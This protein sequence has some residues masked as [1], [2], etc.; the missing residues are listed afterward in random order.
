[1]SIQLPLTIQQLTSEKPYTLDSTGL[2][3]S[4]IRIYDDMVLKIEEYID[5]AENTAKMLRWLDGKLPAPRL[6][7][8][9]IS[10]GKSYM[11]MSRINGRMSCDFLDEQEMVVSM[12]AEGL[13]ML[14][15]VDISDCPCCN[16][17]DVKL[18]AARY[19]VENGLVDT[20]NVQ[21]ETYGDGGFS[22]PA[23][24]LEWLCDN[25]P[26]E[27]LTLTHGDFC[28]P[29]I[30][31]DG[32]K[33]SGFIDLGK[34]GVA[35]RW[36]DIAICW[37]SLKDNYN[38]GY[39]GKVYEDFDPDLLFEKLGIQPDMEKLRYYILLDELF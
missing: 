30:L 23:E 11:L 32:G 31:L 28:L 25:R 19:N 20:E 9:E 17:L 35:D 5:E 38:G 22:G 7:H 33:I 3:G 16:G 2:S 4:Q 13:K 15:G 29:N 37:R 26:E 10:D 8:H 27:E 6:I 21:P 24:L 34:A 12:M 18:A 39:G 1:M 36:T 14:Q